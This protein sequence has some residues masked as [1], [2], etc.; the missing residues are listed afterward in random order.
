M[1]IKS[2]IPLEGLRVDKEKEEI[3]FTFK[4]SEFLMRI[5]KDKRI[6]V[7]QGNEVQ[8]MDQYWIN[9]RVKRHSGLC[10]WRKAGYGR[11]KSQRKFSRLKE[12]NRG[13]QD[14]SFPA[15]KLFQFFKSKNKEHEVREQCS[16]S[17]KESQSC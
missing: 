2:L 10:L 1:L 7:L 9:G 5:T 13:K 11:N 16:D 8:T 14:Q 15:A 3:R 12:I 6:R 17:Q 4:E